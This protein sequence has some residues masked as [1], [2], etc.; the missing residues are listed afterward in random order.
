MNEQEITL[1]LLGQQ[2]SQLAV[3]N[4]QLQARLTVLEDERKEQTDD[5][6]NPERPADDTGGHERTDTPVEPGSQ[7]PS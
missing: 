5:L 3:R 4:A 7:A 2:I 1:A 6:D